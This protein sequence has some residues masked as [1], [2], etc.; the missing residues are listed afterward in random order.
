MNQKYS[1]ANTSIN[2]TKLPAIYK[3]REE[4]LKGKKILDIGGGKYDTAKIW[5]SENESVVAIYDK[6]N[7]SEEENRE[8]LSFQGYDISILSNVLNVIQET[9]I[10]RDL[11]TLAL[12]KAP[13]VY[14][15][16]YEGNGTGIG[17]VSK[18]DCWQENR[19]T[20]DYVEEILSYVQDHVSYVQDHVSVSRKGK[21]IEIRRE[22]A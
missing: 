13:V 2:S 16:V 4:T 17:A 15:T 11:I 18:K 12:D 6:F 14:V 1:S 9:E 21:V 5:A 19:K 10:R 22:V 7:R 3:L 20:D 8:A